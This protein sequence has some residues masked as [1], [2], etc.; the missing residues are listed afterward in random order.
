MRLK[1][2]SNMSEK[3]PSRESHEREG[4]QSLPIEH[5]ALPHYPTADLENQQG[6]HIG[7][8]RHVEKCEYW[9]TP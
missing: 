4:N 6:G 3:L 5:S 7:Q 1:S 2:R 8:E 9:P